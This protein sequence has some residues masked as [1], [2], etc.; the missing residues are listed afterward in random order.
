MGFLIITLVMFGLLW[1]I[2]IRPQQKK[3]N[4]RQNTISEL[5]V[6]D[7]ILTFGGIIGRITNVSDDEFVINSEGST[8][9]IKKRAVAQKVES[10][11]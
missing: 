8:I 10:E 7:N 1:F 9:R 4:E 6:G 3:E 2:M 11:N 5:V